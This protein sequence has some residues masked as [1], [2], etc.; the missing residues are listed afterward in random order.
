MIVFLAD[1]GCVLV[2]NAE[3]EREVRA[4]LPVV[5]HKK[6]VRS[7]AEVEATVGSATGE[8]INVGRALE[9]RRV[10]SQRKKV[11]KEELGARVLPPQTVVL[12]ANRLESNLPDFV[13][14][15]FAERVPELEGVL[16]KN[17]GQVEVGP[18]L[19]ASVSGKPEPVSTGEIKPIGIELRNVQV[20]ADITELIIME[21]GEIESRF[22]EERRSEGANPGDHISVIIG[23]EGLILKGATRTERSHIVQQ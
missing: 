18:P 14:D 8:W 10:I 13:A 22:I 6:I 21:A 1:R 4:H 7:I 3:I 17:L 15:L 12:L 2:S 5:L 16:D 19:Q 23:I 11:V 9:K 20:V